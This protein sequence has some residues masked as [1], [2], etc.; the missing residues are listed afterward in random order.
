MPTSPEDPGYSS[1]IDY[2]DSHIGR[3]V[4][5]GLDR[6]R[7]ALELLADP[8]LGYPVIHIT[9]TNGKTSTARMIASLLGAHGLNAGL[10]TSPHL[11]VVEERFE[12]GGDPMTPAELVATVAEVGPIADLYGERTGDPLT[13]F[14][15]TTVLAFSWFAERTVDVAVVE[16][17]MG[18]RLDSTDIAAAEVAVITTIGLEHTRYLGSTLEEIATEK[19]AILDEGATLVTGNLPREAEDPVEARVRETS[20]SWHRMGESFHPDDIQPAVG[21]WF[22]DIEGVYE[23]YEE[24]ELRSRGRHQVDNF[25]TA[26]AAVESLTSRSLDPDAVRQAADTVTLPGRMELLPARAPL[27]LD[28]A[29][30]PPGAEA[31]AFALRE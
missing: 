9:G 16:T 6:V 2:I 10:F 15:L 13:Y 3:G 26:V 27:I 11:H 24:V 29:H 20:S 30:N 18:G 17:G 12:A 31:L 8:Q 25:T 14:E 28:G 21:G 4:K 7:G 19:V 1:T 23:R 22:F 5:P